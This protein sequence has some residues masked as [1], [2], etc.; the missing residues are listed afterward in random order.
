M[1]HLQ[2]HKILTNEE[3]GAGPNSKVFAY[4]TPPY[5]DQLVIKCLHVDDFY[6]LIPP[7]AGL[8][9]SYNLDHPMI[10]PIQG[11]HLEPLEQNLG[12]NIYQV[13]PKMKECLQKCLERRR[14]SDGQI[15]REDFIVKCFYSII[16]GLEYLH[17]KR[18]AHRNLKLSNILF[19]EKE[20][21]KLADIC[22]GE[23]MNEL[24]GEKLFRDDLWSLGVI[25]TEM[26]FQDAVISKLGLIKTEEAIT[27]Q[28]SKLRGKYSDKL[29]ELITLLLI[30]NKSKKITASDIRKELED[31]YASLCDQIRLSS[32]LSV[33][34]RSLKVL[35]YDVNCL[36][37][38]LL[39]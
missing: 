34:R 20:N 32:D 23:I 10:L 14:Y 13:L 38:F 31:S 28:I 36:N 15:F 19:D 22:Q 3:I 8:I 30:V 24:S 2:K 5:E 26:C 35:F 29:L 21:I 16:C 6:K 7:T 39:R 33:K 17:K 9:L 1:F 18:I 25:I 4:A 27:A 11:F 12:L 37:K